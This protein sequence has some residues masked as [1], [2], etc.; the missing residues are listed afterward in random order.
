LKTLQILLVLF[1]VCGFVIV[2][3]QIVN[4]LRRPI[5]P[6]P[7][8][9]NAPD[10]GKK[11]SRTQSSDS[12]NALPVQKAPPEIVKPSIPRA[13][14]GQIRFA[15]DATFKKSD[16]WLEQTFELIGEKP[17]DG[18]PLLRLFAGL[19][20]KTMRGLSLTLNGWDVVL[21]LSE[22]KDG[23]KRE[24][25]RQPLSKFPPGEY[26][27]GILWRRG[28]LSVWFGAVEVMKWRPD[29]AAVAATIL[30]LDSAAQVLDD[31]VTLGA[32]R[33]M[34]FDAIRFDDNFMRSKANDIW[35]PVAGKWELTAMAF[36]ERSA[37][38]FSLRVSFNDN[39]P[40]EDEIYGGEKR[41]RPDDYGLGVQ[42]SVSEGTPHIVRLTG[43]S[44]AAHAGLAEDDIFIEVN[45]RPV[46][47]ANPGNLWRQLFYANGDLNL[48]MYRPGEKAFREYTIARDAYKWGTSVE[49][50]PIA[51]ILPPGSRSGDEYS[52]VVAG[53]NGWSDYEAE[54]AVK[55]L[56]AGGFGLAV[57]AMSDKDCV[58]FRWRG[59]RPRGDAGTGKTNVLQLVRVKDGVE[60][61]LAEK[62][63][64][65][66]PYEFYR[67]G[68]NWSGDTV[69]CLI[70][71]NEL[72]KATIPDIKRGKIGLYALKGDPV[73]FDD[74]H[75]AGDR[76]IT[77]AWH[78]AERSLNSIF[79]LEDD[80]EIWANPALEFERDVKTG[81]AIHNQRFP[82]EQAISLSKPRFNELQI[83]L[84]CGDNPEAAGCARM[85]IRDGVVVFDAGQNKSDPIKVGPGPFQNISFSGKWLA[86]DLVEVRAKID[87]KDLN[88]SLFVAQTKPGALKSARL[89][90]VAIKGLKN[91]GDPNTVR[92]TS[93]GTLE[94]SF[95][96]A[97]SDWKVVSGRWGLLNKWICDPRWSWFGGRTKTCAAIWNK[98]TFSGDVS[99]DAHVALLMVRDDE[100]FERP[101]DHNI[102]ICGDGINPDSGY[103]LIFGGDINSW[104]RLYRKGKLVAEA[105]K[106]EFRVHSDRIRHPNKQ[107]L[108][109]HWFHLKLE[110][111]G[112]AVSF[113]RDEKLAF[114]FVD[115]EPLSDGR[116]GFWTMD[117]SFLLSRVRIASNGAVPAPFEDGNCERFDD[118]KAVNI[119][120]G[121]TP[122]SV[123]RDTLP[124]E[125]A[126][127]LTARD[128][129]FQPVDG[130]AP[131]P[132]NV[133]ADNV[134]TPGMPNAYRL[135]NGIG[136]GPFALQFRSRMINIESEGVVRFAY[137]IDPGASVDFYLVDVRGNEFNPRHVGCYRWRLSGPKEDVGGT[138]ADEFAPLVGDIPGAIADGKWHAV[139]VDLQPSWRQFW[140][141]RGY[142]Q[143]ARNSL[144]PMFGNLDNTGYLLAG[145]NGNHA[146]AAY[147]VTEIKT[148]AAAKVDTT[149]P[150]I[151]RVIWPFDADG[152]GRSITLQIDEQGGSGLTVESLRCTLN[153]VALNADQTLY[154]GTSTFNSVT[155][156]VRFD[157][158]QFKTENGKPFCLVEGEKYVLKVASN[159]MDRA[160]NV[161]KEEFTSAWTYRAADAKRANKPVTA[162][163][164]EMVRTDPSEQTRG[165][166]PLS[167]STVSAMQPW[168]RVQASQ[169]APSWAP[170]GQKHSIEVI[171]TNELTSMGFTYRGAQYDLNN[172]PYLDLDYKVP[173]ET[174]FNLHLQ[175]EGGQTHSLLLVDVED[176]RDHKSMEIDSRFGPP[177]D[178]IADG[179]WRH[180]TI[181]LLTLFSSA[182]AGSA[183]PKIGGFS[184]HDHGW[185]GGRR[186]LHY[187]IHRIQPVPAGRLSDMSATWTVWDAT[188]IVDVEASVDG[189]PTGDPS[190]KHDVSGVG[191]LE[192]SLGRVKANLKDGWNYIHVRAKNGAGIWS[193]TAHR[194]FFLDTSA[195]RIIK[196]EPADGGTL[197][198]Q[199]IRIYLEEEHGVNLSGLSA[200]LNGS[201]VGQAL[202]YDE[203]KHV[204]KFNAQNA[205]KRMAPGSKN[206]VVINGLA[207]RF[208]NAQSKPYTFSFTS[209]PTS[210]APGP[211]MANVTFHSP[212]QR[213]L[214][215]RQYDM[216]ISFGLSFE[217]HI[218]HVHAMRDCKMEWLNDPA[219]AAEG[220]RALRFTCLQDD[221]DP[222]IMLHKN[223]WFI[224]RLPLL[225]FD[226][227]ADPGFK[228]DLQIEAFGVWYTIRFLSA[229]HAPNEGKSIGAIPGIV[230]DGTWRHASVDLRALLDRAAIRLPDRIV[231]KIVFSANGE[232]GCVR[233]SQLSIDNLDMVPNNAAGYRG[234]NAALKWSAQKS[235]VELA[236]YSYVVDQDPTT[237][238]PE[239]VQ[240]QE[241]VVG[242]NPKRGIYYAHVRA[243]DQAGNWGKEKTIRL[244]FGSGSSSGRTRAFE[245]DN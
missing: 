198:S 65:Y 69:S 137:R 89:E 51:P 95:D 187:W 237:D 28:E 145:M 203:A 85:T 232:D 241:G 220:A 25:A 150:K 107:D 188:G 82:G 234:L 215:Y 8:P 62:P 147:S 7:A 130:I 205:G 214:F 240:I 36:A 23:R 30:K 199:T 83:A 66:R 64:H 201:P 141:R 102:T 14:T 86:S 158:S 43:G 104:T 133:V 179:T 72:L 146:G 11:T 184:F 131:V 45:G 178:F 98:H 76:S 149:A 90:R 123:T 204:L 29:D 87:G 52:F 206:S 59:S 213:G 159:F 21:E 32:R 73:F 71:K 6:P 100:P 153:G 91:L 78:L 34:A 109:Q 63:A 176:A 5:L 183:A 116:V 124:T 161:N 226:Y 196:T 126:A 19:D 167:P 111:I 156:M 122:T 42:I 142:A 114:S 49:A 113:Y 181:P 81:W 13:P 238:P 173:M 9:I 20:D 67:M 171:A 38:P 112:N 115:P 174:P 212:T 233:G 165:S 168:A 197:A 152:D 243:C 139:Q 191:T 101:G 55:P 164:I 208:G 135:V 2:G 138:L 75:V 54:V 103:T 3:S 96:N 61:I 68:I 41:V 200:S 219:L 125:I 35:K 105:T 127:A 218:G 110:K 56:G 60:T 15:E 210:N 160:G 190:G 155:Q 242:L 58:L 17:L 225:H 92:V 132:T 192:E 26:D 136:G 143:P 245:E 74:V 207:D 148:I 230:A 118:G 217:E 175:S 22:S 12:K 185:R 99:V 172:W 211:D 166:R 94:Y 236:G 157:A 235:P 209:A 134:D 162:P 53:E 46:D 44:A 88:A 117:N 170:I 193:E 27:L 31:S 182:N 144:R 128:N 163:L 224:D 195:P 1:V 221:G 169:D 77:A 244:D 33:A 108:H 222:Q 70:D 180:S 50:E 16:F 227:K 37:N 228:V 24:L 48:K 18:K 79:A 194:K 4:R 39:K 154:D 129:A 189:L 120:D 10:V 223:P 80:M 121:E 119:V 216:E 239:R 202:E 140:R 97:P 186:G 177:A 40:F 229:G 106:E 57:A 47:M 151:G 84:Y 93:T 231:N